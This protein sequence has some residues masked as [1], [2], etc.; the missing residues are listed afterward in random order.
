[1]PT[2]AE[3]P[4]EIV[5]LAKFNAFDLTNKRWNYDVAQLAQLARRHDKWWWRLILRTPRLAL[6]V[7][8]VIALA[9]AGVVVVAV[10]N[11]GPDKAARI[12]SC[13]RTHRL[14]A[15]QVS[16]PPRSGETQFQKSDVTPPYGSASTFR[17]TTY[18]S[19]SWPPAPGADADGYE[20]IT[21]TL[22][23]GPGVGDASNRDFADV[24]ESRCKNVRLHYAYEHM[25]DQIPYAAFVARPGGV[26]APAPTAP[27]Y[28]F[29]HV[30]EIG[31]SAQAPLRLPFYPPARATVVLHGQELLQ[32]AGCVD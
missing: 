25:G 32:R 6:R 2:A 1:M 17:Q 27:R 16:R 20:A 22:T 28:S 24:I 3:L 29:A 26:W 8:P 9:V 12:A 19:C 5:P 14:A 4:P 31:S 15:A 11:S 30:T 7:A 21:V 13:E 10:A 23:N 18:A